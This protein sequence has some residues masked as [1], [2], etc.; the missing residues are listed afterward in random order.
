MSDKAGEDDVDI[1]VAEPEDT[2]EK[3]D[4]ELDERELEREREEMVER[5]DDDLMEA[6]GCVWIHRGELTS[7]AINAKSCSS[8]SWSTSRSC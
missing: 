6:E 3:Q 5:G 8:S 4:L 1:D 7:P 2:R